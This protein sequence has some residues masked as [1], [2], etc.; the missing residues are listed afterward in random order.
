MVTCIAFL[1]DWIALGANGSTGVRTHF[2]EV[3]GRVLLVSGAL[4][5][6]LMA[7]WAWIRARRVRRR[8]AR[9]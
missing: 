9:A 5:F 2:W 6:N 8:T 3:P 1:F 4:L 7:L